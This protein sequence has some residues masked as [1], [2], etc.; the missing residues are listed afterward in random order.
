MLTPLRVI[1]GRF[2]F[3]SILLLTLAFSV[4]AFETHACAIE[5][6]SIQ[7]AA[8]ADIA[9]DRQCDDCGPACANGCCHAPHSAV[10][11]EAHSPR[12]VAVFRAPLAWSDAAGL[13]AQ[14]PS[15]PDRPPRA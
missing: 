1:V 9:S 11:P 3:V 7:A 14:R 6:V 15:G 5:P 12:V 8:Q 2:G 4:P 10:A 13:T